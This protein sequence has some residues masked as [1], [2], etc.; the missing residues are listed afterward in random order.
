MILDGIIL[1]ETS[2][3]RKDRY[4]AILIVCEIYKRINRRIEWMVEAQGGVW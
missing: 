2:Q 1:L 4:R 3:T